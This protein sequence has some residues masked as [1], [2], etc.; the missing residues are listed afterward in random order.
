MR[1]ESRAG[2]A[3]KKAPAVAVVGQDT[4]AMRARTA[5]PMAF[6]RALQPELQVDG[7]AS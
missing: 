1:W 7:D 4:P 2:E 5:L 3:Q 6:F